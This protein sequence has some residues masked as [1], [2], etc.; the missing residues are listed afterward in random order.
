MSSFLQGCLPVSLCVGSKAH[1]C[2][3]SGRMVYLHCLE[4]P[5]STARLQ[6]GKNWAPYR[7]T[8]QA[9]V[10]VCCRFQSLSKW[11]GRRQHR[12][13][14]GGGGG[15]LLCMLMHVLISDRFLCKIDDVPLIHFEPHLD[16]CLLL[17]DSTVDSLSWSRD[18]ALLA[19]GERCVVVCIN[20]YVSLGPE[21]A[22]CVC[23]N[24]LSFFEFCIFIGKELFILWAL[25]QV[26]LSCLKWVQG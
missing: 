6:F 22:L 3:S 11:T 2:I 24:Y 16:M 8:L 26:T 9:R 14:G 25:Y 12:G 23:M 10:S 1:L 5:L 4:D 19:V 20:M 21:C 15:G 7:I 18:G 17:V 13:G